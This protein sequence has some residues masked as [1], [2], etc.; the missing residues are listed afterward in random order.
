MVGGVSDVR[1]GQMI[2][3]S[4]G[5]ADRWA[6]WAGWS[7]LGVLVSLLIVHGGAQAVA[8]PRLSGKVDPQAV[9]SFYDHS[10][11]VPIFWQHGLGLTLFAVFL[12]SFRRHLLGFRLSQRDRL[13]T[14]AGTVIGLAVV[15][16]GL[17]EVGL[18]M[19]LVSLAGS[20]ATDGLLSTF[21]AWDWVYNSMFYWLE[22]GWVGCLN[23][24]ALRTGALPRRTA[25]LGLVVALLHVFHSSV[26][27][28]GL[29]DA[30]TLPGTALFVLWFA[31]AGIHLVRRSDR[32]K[33]VAA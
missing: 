29:A 1:S 9:T 23:L 32:A 6:I 20:G 8:G 27:M 13:L 18:Q 17:V 4:E 33:V 30:Y 7:L 12:V 3:E 11:L 24:V 28:L 26:L 2:G 14:D 15:P 22:V 5:M 16:L 19:A 10:Q 31:A 25:L 21:A